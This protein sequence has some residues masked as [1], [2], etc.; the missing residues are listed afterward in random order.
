MKSLSI[1]GSTGSI[2][3]Q[4]L[5]VVNA[6]PDRFT[7]VGLTCGKN[8]ALLKEQI[9]AFK[10]EFVAVADKEAADSLKVDVPVYSG[11]DGIERVAALEA[12]DTVVN[13]LV[14]SSGVKPTLTAINAGKDIA[15]ANKET[16][17]AAGSLVMD[18]VKRKG[19]TLMPID[20]EHSAIFQCLN[21]E[22]M[23]FV[24]KITLTCSGGPFKHKTLE[25]LKSVTKADALS[26]PTWKMG[27]KI[28]ID[29]STLMNKGFEVL[30]THWLYGI[31]YD[32]IDVVVHPQSIIHSLVEFHDRS[33]MA[34][35]GVADMRIPIQYALSYPSRI[36]NDN[37][38]GLDLITQKELTFSAPDLL[39]FPCLGY[40]YAAGRLGG[41]MPCVLNAANEVA[42]AAFLSG[43]I[44]YLEIA[45]SVKAAMDAHT[46]VKNP[47]VDE[48]L[49]IDEK[50]KKS[51]L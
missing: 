8:V 32:Q 19:V 48:I 41:S 10:P 49:E 30:E 45:S 3:V 16:L 44:S 46:L 31:G 43:K 29:S 12:A 4:T 15:L 25:E 40:A 39:R 28:T 37:L 13:S 38:N 14:G 1:L 5:D 24:N 36:K 34:Q 50:I 26:H 47:T 51:A 7:V 17:V 2:G 42:V 33:V 11:R 22:K 20:S 23:D 6:F 21:G 27:D 35:L 9:E 18:A